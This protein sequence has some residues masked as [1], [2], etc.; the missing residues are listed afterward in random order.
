M[1]PPRLTLESLT[2]AYGDLPVLD[3]VSLTVA[4]GEFVALVGPSGCGKSTLFD[5]VAGLEPAD[6][7]PVLPRPRECFRGCLTSAL[8]AI[9][10]DER[11]A[12]PRLDLDNEG[13]E[14]GLLGRA[15]R[16]HANQ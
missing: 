1:A 7:G 16:G 8:P 2:K 13:L 5:V 14:V 6:A 3:A 15:V 11:P 10:R 4:A 9:G 12:Q